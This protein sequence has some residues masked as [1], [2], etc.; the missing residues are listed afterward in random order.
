MQEKTRVASIS[1]A[2]NTFLTVSKITIGLLSGSVSILSEGIHSSIDLVAAIIALFAVKES[3]KPADERHTYGHGKIE[4][5]SGT[6]EAALIFVAAI[7]IIYEAAQKIIYGTEVNN[8]G[9]GLIIMGIS[10]LTNFIVS[11]M[12]IRTAKKTESVALKADA[13]HLR[14]DV[15]TSLG[16]L[17]GLALMK[18]TGWTIL[19]P[20]AAIFVALLIIKAAYDLTKEAFMPLVDVSLPSHEHEIITEILEAHAAEYVEFHGLRTRRAGSERHIDLHL[21]VPRLVPVYEVHR[22]CDQIEVEIAERLPR[23]SVLIH[24]EPCSDL[25]EPCPTAHPGCEQCTIDQSV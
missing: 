11:S 3:G 21:V 12:L 19:D 1:V 20:L 16:V 2:S 6:I 8:L 25:N 17:A 22:L 7:W 18:L 10:A 4:N 13:M 14:T 24:A 23:S 15:Y 5:V 9:F